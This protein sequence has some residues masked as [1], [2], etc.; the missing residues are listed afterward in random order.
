MPDLAQLIKKIALDAV[1]ASAP[2]NVL[3]GTVTAT[4]PL[5]VRISARLI[6]RRP[7]LKSL[8]GLELQTGDSVAVLRAAGG[9]VWLVL[10]RIA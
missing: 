2:A 1:E 8:E 5:T 3:F 7:A 6:I 10:G 4:S 9:Q